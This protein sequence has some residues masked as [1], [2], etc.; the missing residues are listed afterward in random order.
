MLKINI[1]VFL[2]AEGRIVGEARNSRNSRNSSG[3]RNSSGSRFSSGSRGAG[4]AGVMESDFLICACARKHIAHPGR[5]FGS[6]TTPSG[7]DIA[8]A[9]DLTALICWGR[10]DFSFFFGGDFN[11]FLLIFG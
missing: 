1:I 11:N 10:L 7:G 5:P 8:V 4:I 9:G 3:A 2:I 6:S